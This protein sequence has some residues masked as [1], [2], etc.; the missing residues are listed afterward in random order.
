MNVLP[1]YDED[2]HQEASNMAHEHTAPP[3]DI[4]LLLQEIRS[5]NQALSD[6][7]DKHTTE[8]NQSISGLKTALDGLKSRVNETEDR[9]GA[10]ED[11]LS[12]VSA[13]VAKLIKDKTFLMDKVDSL[14]NYSR[15][16]NIRLINLREGC[17]GNDPV[18]FFTN[19][20]PIILGREEFAGP[21]M[22]ERAHRTLG[23]KPSASE[24]P[25]PV[26][27]RLL[28]YQDREKILRTAAKRYKE[29]KS[30]ITYEDRPL[31]FFPDLS[32]N[33]VKR[34]KEFDHVK[35]E[36]RS[37]NIQYSLLHPATLRITLADGKRKI[38][39]TPGEAA[40]F[41]KE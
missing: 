30:P 11:E 15:R 4:A 7:L 1:S 12:D 41:L 40:A 3:M 34:R 19:W 2:L 26:L 39:Q 27:I 28:N 35:G 25:R 16:N 32:P 18:A 17:E 29:N 9:I 23:P 36:L 33:L 10:V 5:G 38:F 24:R 31:M 6:K 37:R 21:L 13:Q 20:L 14:E 22:I 8:I